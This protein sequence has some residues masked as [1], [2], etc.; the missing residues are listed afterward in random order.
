MKLTTIL[1]LGALLAAPMV[2][3]SSAAF[4][5]AG[6]NEPT[7]VETAKTPQAKHKATKRHGKHQTKLQGKH[8][9][10]S[11]HHPMKHKAA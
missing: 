4:A 11:V 5:A 3:H 2:I 7:A 10:R 6:S 8:Y 9:G 1:A